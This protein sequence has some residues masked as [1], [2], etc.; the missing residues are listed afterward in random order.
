MSGSHRIVK[1]PKLGGHVSFAGRDG[2]DAKPYE[3]KKCQRSGPQIPRTGLII[4]LL[5]SDG[6]TKTAVGLRIVQIYSLVVSVRETPGSRS[7]HSFQ[8]LWRMTSDLGSKRERNC[9]T[10]VQPCRNLAAASERQALVGATTIVVRQRC[11]LPFK[12]QCPAFSRSPR[13]AEG[14][15]VGARSFAAK[16]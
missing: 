2:D 16:A 3:E 5:T 1:H 4:T 7:R 11:S 13:R 14:G 8:F 6:P 12:T 15:L 10:I 9:W